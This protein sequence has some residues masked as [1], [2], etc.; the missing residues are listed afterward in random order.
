MIHTILYLVSVTGMSI[1]HYVTIY[2]LALILGYILMSNISELCKRAVDV[3]RVLVTR[4]LY[5]LKPPTVC[6]G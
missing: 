4:C 2:W 5:R 3:A 6:A 1:V